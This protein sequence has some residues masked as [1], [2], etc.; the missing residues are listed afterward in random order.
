MTEGDLKKFKLKCK[1]IWSISWP[2]DDSLINPD[3]SVDSNNTRVI[4]NIENKF[5]RIFFLIKKV[6]D[7]WW[8]KNSIRV[9]NLVIFTLWR[10][11]QTNCLTFK[12]K[13]SIEFIYLIK[14][15]KKI[16]IEIYKLKVWKWTIKSKNYE[17]NFFHFVVYWLKK[18]DSIIKSTSN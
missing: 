11:K 9:P 2:L 13:K 6:I 14:M 12:K 4:S 5:R 7:R 17:L 1:I 8:W 3:R 10:S 18:R 16:N 15:K